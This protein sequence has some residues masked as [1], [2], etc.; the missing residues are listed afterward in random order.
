MAEVKKT[1]KKE[2]VNNDKLWATLAHL[3]G[4]LGFVM[5]FGNIVAPL[6]IWLFRKHSSEFVSDQAREALNFQLSITIYLVVAGFLIM[7]LV[8]ILLLPLLAL[9][10]VVVMIQAAIK[11]NNGEKYHYPFTFRFV[12]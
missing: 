11:A 1:I 3:S 4:F 7:L 5:P 10:A 6:L 8:G 2:S 9:F 12:K